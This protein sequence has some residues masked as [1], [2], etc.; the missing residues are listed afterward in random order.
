MIRK[1]LAC[2]ALLP[3]V[4]V[5]QE[6][7]NHWNIKP[8]SHSQ[9]DW[10]GVGLLQTPTARMA[11]YGDLSINYKDNDEYRYW[12]VSLQLFPWLEST[13]RYTDFRNL[14]F[15]SDPNFSGD[16]TAKDKGIDFKFR[17][18]EESFYLP[19]LALGIRDFGG[20][21]YF[22]SE[23][24]AASKRW[25]DFDFHLGIGWGY[26]G[27]SD[28]IGNPFCSLD[29]HFCER[30]RF[31]GPLVDQ[32]GSLEV[33]DFFSGPASLFG[34]IEYQTPWAP[35]RLS[36]EYEG[37]DYKNER[38]RPLV[39]DSR[40]NFGINYRYRDFDFNLSWERGNTLGFGFT[41]RINV[42]TLR[43]AKI[44]T[45]AR[46][47]KGVEPPATMEDMNFSKVR[48]DL[49]YEAGFIVTGGELKED[50]VTLFGV[51][52]RYRNKQEAINRIGRVLVTEFPESVEEF[53]IVNRTGRVPIV[54]TVID[55]E[56]FRQEASYQS[57]D[58]D[59]ARAVT[60]RDP[61]PE[62][63]ELIPD[64]VQGGFFTGLEAF[65]SQTFANPE[66]FY[67]YQGGLMAGAGY[68]FG[69]NYSIQGMAKITLLEN[70]DKFKFLVDNLDTTL[71]RVR[72]E[73]RRYVRKSRISMDTLYGQ[74]YDRIAPNTYAQ[75]YA[76]YLETMFGGVGGEVLYQPVDSN[77]AVGMD[78]NYVRQRSWE[79][80]IDFFN[81]KAL[82]GHVN[83][84]WEPGFFPD[85]RLTFK[86]GQFLAKDK[87]L[88]ID[89]AKKFDSGI[90]FG[91]YAAFTN[92]SAEE[93]GEG[94]FTKGFYISI[95]FDVFSLSPAKGRGRIPWVPISRDGGQ[96]L[97]RPVELIGLTSDRSMFLD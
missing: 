85:T 65:W 77:W 8:V 55:A 15:S 50:E 60:R 42:D 12:T 16:Q 96:L 70:F 46:S 41:Y 6:Q 39:Q 24:L 14:L 71:P 4:A 83:A 34:G 5:A 92:V 52:S 87:G 69:N 58:S 93:Y 38:A 67:L 48:Q 59:I 20:T 63:L 33:D 72:T 56:Q 84:Y 68:S 64:R 78:L 79:N 11:D 9:M 7:D 36:L 10:G 54:E 91:A 40:W 25:G 32:G 47:I 30:E 37:N 28:N 44:D 23:F 45:S 26:L 95:P 81:Y 89:F 76:G 90:V 74:W 94:S 17:L 51:Q 97:H 73:I 66:S 2:C 57:L 3:I 88:H 13:V 18:L 19:E 27:N 1:L 35:L 75:V 31:A 22:E 53:R 61:S 29:D 86:L 21:G 82:T 80:D 43:Q 62:T 49:D